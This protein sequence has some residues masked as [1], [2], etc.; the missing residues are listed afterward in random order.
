MSEIQKSIL[1]SGS[2]EELRG[3]EGKAAVAYFHVLN[4]LI[5]QQKD[6]FQFSSRNKRPPEDAVNAMMSFAYTLLAHDCAAA[7]ESVGLDSYVGFLH[8]DRPGRTSLALDL[9]EELRPAVAD[10]MVLTL[11]N[12]REIT[13][14][15]FLYQ[16]DGAV[17]LNDSGRKIFL[18]K[19]QEKKKEMLTHPYLKEKVTWGLIP[20][21]QALLLARHI[22]TDLEEYPPF[23]W[24]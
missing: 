1:A 3:Y 11:I 20:Y 24:K 9:E 12:N 10:R 6:V 15:H 21:V 16:S 4:E 5:L 8:K 22:R 13:E 7:L 2:T 17:L 19:W 18:K 23:L 14:K